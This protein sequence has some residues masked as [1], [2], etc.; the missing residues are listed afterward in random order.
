[1]PSS[2]QPDV[3][4]GVPS[5]DQPVPPSSSASINFSQ[6]LSSQTRHSSFQD[7]PFSHTH[8]VRGTV[9]LSQSYHLASSFNLYS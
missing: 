9:R 8:L 1:M 3:T 5:S 4:D 6:V 7:E 2:L